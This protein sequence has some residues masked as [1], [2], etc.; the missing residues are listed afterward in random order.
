MKILSSLIVSF[1]LVLAPIA[2]TASAQDQQMA[3]KPVDEIKSSEF[4]FWVKHDHLRKSCEGELVI[5]EEGIEYI[6]DF[7]EH[8]RY[9]DFVDIKLLKLISKNEIE[10]QTYTRY[11]PKLTL[12]QSL[13]LGRDESFR[14]K[15][16]EGELTQKVS[17][18]L[19]KKTKKP[20]ATSFVAVDDETDS[21]V[22]VLRVRHRHRWGGCPGILKVYDD[23]VI[24]Q[25]YTEPTDSR[26]WRWTD[27]QGMGRS[28]PFKFELMTY[29]P[30]LGGPEKPYNFDLKEEMTDQMYDFLWKKFYKVTY[31][32]SA[33]PKP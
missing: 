15:V 10:V 27:L 3:A 8:Q 33:A 2:S 28:G 1:C 9:W 13:K 26:L 24:Y 17:Q 16:V 7:E 19:Q 29:E 21:P 12:N 31:Y 32:P 22:F 11:N 25:S 6:T 18:F 14:F 20:M 5:N 23:K 30:Q 4:R